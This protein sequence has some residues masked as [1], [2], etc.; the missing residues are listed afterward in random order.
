MDKN[1]GKILVNLSKG[2]VRVDYSEGIEKLCMPL[3]WGDSSK[4]IQILLILFLPRYI[5]TWWLN[6]DS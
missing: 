6:K 2:F 4:S 1:K 3:F 5:Y